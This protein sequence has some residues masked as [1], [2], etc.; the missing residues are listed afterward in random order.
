[1][2]PPV[3]RIGIKG[4]NE[5]EMPKTWPAVHL[6][7][8]LMAGVGATHHFSAFEAERNRG[9]L[10][11]AGLGWCMTICSPATQPS[12]LQRASALT[13]VAVISPFALIVV[14]TVMST[15]ELLFGPLPMRR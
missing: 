8:E 2:V 6:Q 7:S 4:R 11:K 1:M 13:K 15:V 10:S 5:C 9:P 12:S 14:L 3:K